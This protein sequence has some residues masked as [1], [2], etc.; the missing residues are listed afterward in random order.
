MRLIV[1]ML[2]AAAAVDAQPY[3]IRLLSPEHTGQSYAVSA[4]GS[5][6]NQTKAGDRVVQE[7]EYQIAFEGQA[8]ILKVDGK[9]RPIRLAFTVQKFEKITGGVT[10]EVL[11]QGSVVVVDGGEQQAISLKDGSIDKSAREAFELVYSAHK[12]ESPTDD[13]IF[14][15]EEK[16]SAGESWPMHRALAAENLKD[17]GISIPEE[18][19]SGTIS[20]VGKGKAGT[21]DCLEVQGEMKADGFSFTSKDAVPGFTL[22]KGSVH[23][24]LSGCIPLDDSSLS[25][26]EGMELTMQMRLASKEGTVLDVTTSQKRDGVW[27]PLK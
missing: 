3:T 11:K 4:T 19:L 1:S 13:E 17:S 23:A 10:A 9:Q 26:R 22:E 24:R 20:L 15:T 18:R 25:R 5:Q 16:K 21:A 7:L 2:L 14:G 12:P 27:T 8:E 6:H